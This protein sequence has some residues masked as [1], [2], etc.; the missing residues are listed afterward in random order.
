V[1]AVALLAG[2]QETRRSPNLTLAL[3]ASRLAD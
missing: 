2:G 3:Y 1:G